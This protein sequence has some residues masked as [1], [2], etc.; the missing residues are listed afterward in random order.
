MNRLPDEEIRILFRDAG[1]TSYSLCHAKLIAKAQ[2]TET[3]LAD[4]EWLDKHNIA[5]KHKL[6]HLE[7]SY[8]NWQEF[9]KEDS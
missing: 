4:V 9:I 5:P 1:I 7:I 6:R 8:L 2:N 3:H